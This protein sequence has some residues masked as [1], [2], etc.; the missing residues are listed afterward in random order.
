MTKILLGL[1]PGLNATGW[2]IIAADGSRLGFV[3]SGTARTDSSQPL[4]QRLALLHHV[5]ANVLREFSP[6]S[7]AVEETFMNK[8]A[9]G[10]LKLGHARGVAILAPAL[11]NIPVSEY[12]PNQVKKTVVGVGHADKTQVAHMVKRLLPGADPKSTDAADALAVAICHAL[13][14]PSIA[15]LEAAGKK[16]QGVAS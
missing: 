6:D 11:L 16:R 4:A 13:T 1:D 7:V 9:R 8:D 2:G 14:V 5:L 10:A 15:R 12:A 3:A